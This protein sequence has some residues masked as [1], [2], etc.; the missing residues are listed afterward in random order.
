MLHEE[1]VPDS[2]LEVA[3]LH[4]RQSR[5]RENRLEIHHIQSQA[6]TLY[7]EAVGDSKSE[8]AAPRIRSLKRFE[9]SSIPIVI[10]RRRSRCMRRLSPTASRRSRRCTRSWARCTP[11]ACS[12]PT[13]AARW[14]TRPL[15]FRPSCCGGGTSAARCSLARTSSGS[16]R[17]GWRWRRQRRRR[18][19]CGTGGATTCI[20]AASIG[21]ATV[22]VGSGR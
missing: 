19:R 17:T 15:A 10:K 16:R 2:S 9:L 12:V 5:N 14:R 22:L 8:A 20:D 6:F 11:A 13:H 4:L 1:A 7:E 18:Q 3:A 21:N